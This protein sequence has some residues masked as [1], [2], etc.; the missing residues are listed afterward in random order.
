MSTLK[1]EIVDHCEFTEEPK[2]IE[3]QTMNE[4]EFFY[5][6]FKIADRYHQ[7]KDAQIEQLRLISRSL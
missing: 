4:A 1:I 5:M 7:L 3:A 6:L 2:E